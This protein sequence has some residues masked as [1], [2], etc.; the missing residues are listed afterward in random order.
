MAPS[1]Q[2]R[3]LGAL[4]GVHAGDSFGA[5]H[6]FQSWDAIRKSFPPKGRIPRAITGGGPFHWSPGHATDDTDMTRAVLLA[7]SEA[8][9][10]GGDTDTF[11]SVS[12]AAGQHMLQWFSGDGWPGRPDGTRPKDVGGATAD[13]L[14]RFARQAKRDPRRA[15]AGP[16]RCGNG[17][18]MRCIPT[19]LFAR[20]HVRL[21]Q[22]TALISAITHDDGRCIL[23]CVAYNVMVRALVGDDT[24]EATTPAAAVQRALDVLRD[25]TTTDVLVAALTGDGDGGRPPPDTTLRSTLAA[26]RDEVVAA[27]EKARGADFDVGVLADV[28]PHKAVLASG[29]KCLRLAGNG[30]VLES[31][32]LA[33]AAVLDTQRSWEDLIVDVVRVGRD[34]DTNGAIAGGLVGARDGVDAIPAAWRAKLQFRHEFTTLV[35]TMGHE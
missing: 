7:Y 29:D 15:G 4:L 6:E 25:P 12:Q 35:D 18:L 28:G 16:G 10:S 14:H 24:T 19:A 11:L 34:T 20:D 33:V 3:I 13:G 26:H 21:L 22:E 8:N 2:Q 1:R 31:L 27:I 17:S 9:R 5:A 30:Y 32:S 23:A